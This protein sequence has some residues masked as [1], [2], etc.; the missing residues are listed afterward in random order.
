MCSDSTVP[1]ITVFSI[2]GC[3]HCRRAK[4]RLTELS[5][6][7]VEIS[8]TDLPEAR[9]HMTRLSK[10]SL[11]V[12]QI[13]IGDTHI[14]GADDLFKISESDLLSQCNSSDIPTE[15]FLQMD[16]Y[17]KKSVKKPMNRNMETEQKTG[18]TYVEVAGR[19]HQKYL[20]KGG[21]VAESVFVGDMKKVFPKHTKNLISW[22]KSTGIVVVVKGKVEIQSM[23]EP[24]LLNSFRKWADRV[25]DATVTVLSLKEQYNII[26]ERHVNKKGKVNY[27]RIV[28]DASWLPFLESLSEIRA[29]N[30]RKLNENERKAFL[31][32]VYNLFIPIAFILRGIPKGNMARYS[33]FDDIKIDIG[34]TPLSFN[35]IES[36]L[37]RTNAKAP[38]HLFAPI[39]SGDPILKSAVSLDKRIHFALNCGAQSC[40]PVKTFT[41]DNLNDQLN[42][43][44][45]A[46]CQEN[47]VVKGPTITV[48]EIFKWY[49]ADFGSSKQLVSYLQQVTSESTSSKIK[50]LIKKDSFKINYAPYNWSTNSSASNEYKTTCCCTIS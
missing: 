16:A 50:A 34:G 6:P 13:F 48:S 31:I 25:D 10:G 46:F 37:L 8:L 20:G 40:P 9:D 35:Q 7:F 22:M 28:S 4:S 33:F 1:V 32:N 29:I 38:F 42:I 3:P 30:L 19:L 21:E 24:S 11:T 12:P 36:G 49:A 47:V 45:E 15:R 14:G 5:I 2:S 23:R 39:S 44:A 41:P 17:S 18:L 26:E 27:K 43:V